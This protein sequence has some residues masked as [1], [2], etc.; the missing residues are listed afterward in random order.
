LS[1]PIPKFSA[2]LLFVVV[3]EVKTGLSAKEE[4]KII[5]SFWGE[6]PKVAFAT[7]PQIIVIIAIKT[8]SRN[9]KVLL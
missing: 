5:V 7:V 3:F 1:E 6:Q 8:A 9:A 2:N 4:L